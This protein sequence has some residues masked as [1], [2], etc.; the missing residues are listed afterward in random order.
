[1]W[2][3]FILARAPGLTVTAGDRAA[4]A[5][6]LGGIAGLARARLMTPDRMPADQPFARDGSGP[7]LALQL[8]FASSDAAQAALRADSALARLPVVQ[9]LLRQDLPADSVTH[10]LMTARVFPTGASPPADP[11]LTFFVSYRG[12]AEDPQAWLDHYDKHHPPIMVRFPGIREVETYRPMAWTSEL[13]FARAA[14]LQRNKVVFASLADLIAALASPVMAEIR[15]DMAQFPPFTLG[16][17]H[18]PM[19]TWRVAGSGD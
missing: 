5:R 15:A 13:P 6:A 10:E 2:S 18:F 7:D 16:N 4:I 1:M 12:P 19:T 9:D 14:S 8:Y 17:T 11:F 3:L